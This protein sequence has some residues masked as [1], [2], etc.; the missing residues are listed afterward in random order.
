MHLTAEALQNKP[1]Y[2]LH[3]IKKSITKKSGVPV[4]WSREGEG[5]SLAQ[6]AGRLVAVGPGVQSPEGEGERE[7][8]GVASPTLWRMRRNGVWNAVGGSRCKCS[9][10]NIIWD[11]CQK[12]WLSNRL[13]NLGITRSR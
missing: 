7:G 1:L 6:K 2:A 4:A 10:D 8:D 9:L 3:R 5:Q 11:G 12:G 13:G